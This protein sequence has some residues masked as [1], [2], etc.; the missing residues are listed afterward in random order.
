MLMIWVA[1]GGNRRNRSLSSFSLP[2]SLPPSL[3]ECA[4]RLPQDLGRCA[5]PT[6]PHATMGVSASHRALAARR[7]P[8]DEPIERV[9]R[10]P[11]AVK[12]LNT[13][14]AFPLPSL[15]GQSLFL[16][17]LLTKNH[18]SPVKT[19]DLGGWRWLAGGTGEDHR[20]GEKTASRA[21]QA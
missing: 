11:E 16:F 7:S 3:P 13:L 20:F 5:R 21:R 15:P 10:P 4:Q 1:R 12:L 8:W 19:I 2:P 6:K 9:K 17:F 18:V 14:P